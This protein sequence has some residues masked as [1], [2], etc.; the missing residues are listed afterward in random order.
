M[1][2][3][4]IEGGH[5]VISDYNLKVLDVDTPEERIMYLIVRYPE[6]GESYNFF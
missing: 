3:W 5:I 6:K 4:I 1:E 2:I